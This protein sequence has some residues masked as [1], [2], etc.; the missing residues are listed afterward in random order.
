[1][2][3][4]QDDL[5]EAV[6]AEWLAKTEIPSDRPRIA[7]FDELVISNEQTLM[8]DFA[9]IHEFDEP[10]MTEFAK[11]Y[12]KAGDFIERFE[13]G[14][15]PVKPEL[16]K[17]S[18]ISD[19]ETL[20]SKFADLILNSQVPVPF[21]LSVDTD[22]KDAVHY[23]MTFSGAGLILPDTTYYADEHPRKAELLDFY[24]TNTVEILREF[25]F[26]AEAAQQQV[27]NTVKFDAILA[28]Y[29][30]TSEEWAKYA[31]LYN[32][33]VISDFTSHIKSVPFAQI[34]EAL[35]GKLPEKIVVYEKRFYENF[36]QIVNVANFELIKSWM[37]VKLL[38]GSTQ[39]L[40][41]DMRILGSDF[42]RKLSG[43]SEARSQ[44]KHAFDLATGQF[45]QAVGLYYGHKYFG[46]AA[47]AD[48]QRMT[49]EMIKVYQ[50]RLDKNTWLSRAT[51]DKAI[52]KLDAMTVFIGFPDKL[53]EIYQQFTVSHD[54]LYSNI[55]RFDVA[56]SH[57]HYD[58]FN[59]DVD[60][61]EWHMPA[62]MVNAYFSPDS[63]TIVFPAAILQ[64]PFY[65]ATEQTPSQNYGGI[66]AVIAHEISHAFDNNGALFDEFGNMNNWWTDEDFKAFEAKQELMIAEFDGLEIAGGK[67]N[68]KLVV[69]E[70]IADAGGL[71]A[72]M[73][74]ALREP[75]AD[76][77]AF[78][79]QWG[80]I[81]RLKASEEY[82]QMLLSMDVHAPGKLRANVQA[83]NLDEFFATFDIQEGDGMWRAEVERVKIW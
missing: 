81:W 66:G 55:A 62:H 27:E 40:S 4:I 30:N 10:V 1:M 32:P 5:F 7:A 68:G 20:T 45:S 67:V 2:V 75:D 33:V 47:K 83:S 76:L 31:E 64:K 37:L 58:K 78:F 70:N 16:E 74:A 12:K 48:V 6:N 3:R 9:T 34:I 82:Q 46:E 17:I 59:E 60:K 50:E 73:T 21:G 29:V 80:E 39:Y 18:A 15:E 35:I 65:S 44:E 61:T 26:S 28:Q 52:K 22:M 19:F 49:S 51:I 36:D 71:T 25:G 77:K 11:F 41:D 69:S 72:A 13:F 57:K 63:N 14:T 8:H 42:S 79:T 24:R 23:A 43:T 54:S 56:R 53:P 38:R